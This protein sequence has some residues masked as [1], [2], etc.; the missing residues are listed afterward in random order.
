V[1]GDDY[2]EVFN[3]VVRALVKRLRKKIEGNDTESDLI[4]SI[5]GVGYKLPANYE[6]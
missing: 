2:D 3:E 4:K 1:W 5:R 6:L